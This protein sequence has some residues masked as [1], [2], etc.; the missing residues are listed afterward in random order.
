MVSGNSVVIFPFI[1][2]IFSKLKYILDVGLLENRRLYHALKNGNLKWNK[3]S[4]KSLQPRLRHGTVK[5]KHKL[6]LFGGTS[7]NSHQSGTYND[8][9]KF[10]FLRKF[11]RMTTT[12]SGPSPRANFGFVLCDTAEKI[13]TV[14]GRSSNVDPFMSHQNPFEIHSLNPTSGSWQKIIT[15]GTEPQFSNGVRSV[16]LNPTELVT[17]AALIPTFHNWMQDAVQDGNFEHLRTSMQVSILKFS[18]NSVERGTWH[19]VAD[20]QQNRRGW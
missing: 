13:F 17:V 19:R 7:G 12:G 11:H 18:N 9:W 5:F 6:I 10:D 16:M 15:T 20:W 1:D 14:G 3:V 2:F 4:V 8:V